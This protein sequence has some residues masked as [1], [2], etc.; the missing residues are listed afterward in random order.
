[1]FDYVRAVGE[2][3]SLTV[4]G[5]HSGRLA[6]MSNED[7][8][9]YRYA[10]TRDIWYRQTSGTPRP[11]AGPIVWI[12]LNPSTANATINDPTIRKCSQFA[13]LAGASGIIVLN[14]YAWR[15][16]I[17]SILSEVEDPVGPLND[18]V[19]R[20][21]LH[22]TPRDSTWIV[23]WGALTPRTNPCDRT[24]AVLDMMREAGRV[25]CR[26]GALTHGGDPRHPGRIAYTT[27]IVEYES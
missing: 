2:R 19:I 14:L 22:E 27:P 1:M 5:D 6:V 13:A 26:L 4:Q 15:S 8:P 12:M 21:V 18:A 23:A 24:D 20:E 17:P 11:S 3:L 7:T 25:P 10:L 9:K 16:V